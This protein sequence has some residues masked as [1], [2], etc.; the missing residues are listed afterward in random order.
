MILVTAATGKVG[1]ELVDLLV[2]K[3]EAVAAV[4]RNPSAAMLPH[5]ARVVTGDPSHPATLTSAHR[6]VKAVFLNPASLGN[7]AADLLGR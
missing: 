2:Q 5:G 3:D 4:T 7:A 1:R 6:G